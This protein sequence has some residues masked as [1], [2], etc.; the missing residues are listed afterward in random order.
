[1]KRGRPPG[2][3]GA[4][5]KCTRCK[6]RKLRDDFYPNRANSTGHCTVCRQCNAAAILE[7]RYLKLGRQKGVSELARMQANLSDRMMLLSTVMNKLAREA[8]TT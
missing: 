1:M 7:Q 3:V 5:L 8:T 4:T 6:A 2:V